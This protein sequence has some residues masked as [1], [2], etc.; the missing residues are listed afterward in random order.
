M[1]FQLDEASIARFHERG[2]VVLR[3]VFSPEWIEALTEAV[4]LAMAHPSPLERTYRPADGTA[5][6]FQ[7]YVTWQRWAPL[8]R[9]V[10][11]SNAGEV[12]AKL[13]RSPTAR[14]FHDHMLVKEPGNSMVTPWHQDMPYYCVEG[15]QSVSF[16][17]PLDPVAREVCMECVAGSHRW[18]EEGFRPLRFTG[19]PL[20]A[21]DHYKPL[22]DIAANRHLYELDAW[23]LEPGDAIAFDFRT[24]HGAPANQSSTRR[25]VISTRWVGA[26]ATWAVR[27]GT[28]SPPFTHLAA[29]NLPHGAP[30]PASDF[31]QV[32]P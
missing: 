6:F 26:D 4:R 25:R 18:S 3:G 10:R 14:F 19:A 21:Q 31:P 29:L 27:E 16:W 32:Y 28:T 8:E 13:M 5:P 7:D 30:L 20:Y 2:V 9:F 23:A 12:A 1:S 17:T 24:V 15:R 11:E 22:P